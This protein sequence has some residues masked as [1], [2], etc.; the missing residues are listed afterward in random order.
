MPDPSATPG[1]WDSPTSKTAAIPGC[2]RAAA[3]RASVSKRERNV[4]SSAYSCLSSL[5][6][7]GRSRAVSVP[8]HTSP[9]PPVAIRLSSR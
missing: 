6:A 7:T 2:C 1:A 5:I 9:M 8:R 3:C 4:A